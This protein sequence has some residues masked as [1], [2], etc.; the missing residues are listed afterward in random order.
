VYDGTTHDLAGITNYVYDAQ[1]NILSIYDFDPSGS[2][3]LKERNMY[4]N[5]RLGINTDSIEMVGAIPV[6][7]LF[8]AD[9]YLGLKQFELSNHLGNVL[10][11]VSDKKLSYSIAGDSTDFSQP[12]IVSAN[13]YYA[14]GMYMGGRSWSSDE[15][16][17]GFN[18]KEKDDETFGIE[19]N[20]YD[21]GARIYN[22]RL[23]RWLS[24]DKF[25]LKYPFASP[26][27]FSLNSPV[28]VKD[29]GGD[30]AWISNI[31]KV[32]EIKGQ[33]VTTI[34][35]T[36]HIEATILDVSDYPL[37]PNKMAQK[38]E[39][40]LKE[41]LSRPSET[42]QNAG[43]TLV[44]NYN[45]DVKVKVAKS[46]DDVKSTDHLVVVVDQVNSENTDG[47]V[48]LA[49][50]YS[51]IAYVE[52]G[53]FTGNSELVNITIHE[54]AHDIG[55]VLDDYDR[56]GNYMAR[57]GSDSRTFDANQIA[58]IWKGAESGQA[59]TGENFE[60]ADHSAANFL[61]SSN[62]EQPYDWSVD[63]GDKMPRTIPSSSSKSESK[64]DDQK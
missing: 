44:I 7:S 6:C 58:Q 57:A 27:N 48:G 20:E 8:T 3:M 2:Y 61:G 30:S 9:H 33:T 51:Q 52:N 37:D 54:I 42:I 23:G 39:S 28:M 34:T 21:F 53:L 62:N 26:Y 12:E 36:L 56:E 24:M 1:G 19:G 32:E 46:M 50:S 38:T 16:R 60:V 10:A 5:A 18:S 35:K 41:A 63:K 40:K 17:F 29:V 14:F 55:G 13:D 31:V 25:A 11:V 4:G 45:V 49:Y 22:S 59:N 64:S 43:G 47:A 15:Y